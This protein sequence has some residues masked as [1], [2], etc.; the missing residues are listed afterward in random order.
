[1]SNFR[2][3]FRAKIAMSSQSGKIQIQENLRNEKHHENGADEHELDFPPTSS[4]Y[5]G[6]G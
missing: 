6:I 4:L 3:S 1:M 2:V 5:F